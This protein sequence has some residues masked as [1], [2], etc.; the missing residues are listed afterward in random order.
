MHELLKSFLSKKQK[1]NKGMFLLLTYSTCTFQLQNWN[2]ISFNLFFFPEHCWMLCY[3]SVNMIKFYK[4][5]S[6]K[7]LLYNRRHNKNM[8]TVIIRVILSACLC[9]KAITIT[10][11]VVRNTKEYILINQLTI[12]RCVIPTILFWINL[13]IYSVYSLIVIRY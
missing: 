8:V 13:S 12:K 9:H 2:V 4:F 7:P 10:A 6:P 5:T 11:S 3:L 1:K